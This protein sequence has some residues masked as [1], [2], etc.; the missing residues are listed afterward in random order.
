MQLNMH[1][2][3]QKIFFRNAFSVKIFKSSIQNA[4]PSQYKQVATPAEQKAFI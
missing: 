1:V 2:W 4:H 3:I